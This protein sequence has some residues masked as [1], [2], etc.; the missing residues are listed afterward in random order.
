MKTLLFHLGI[1][2]DISPSITELGIGFDVLPKEEAMKSLNY[3]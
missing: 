1:A 3:G 2:C